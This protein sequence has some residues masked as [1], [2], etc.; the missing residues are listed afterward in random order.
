MDRKFNQRV[1]QQ[2]RKAEA[3]GQFKNLD[4]AG[5]P[6]PHRPG[7]ALIDPMDSVGHRIMAEAGA[8]PEEV[9]LKKELDAL[10]K[11]FGDTTDPDKRKELMPKLADLEM[12]YNIAREA[13][14]K[15]LGTAAP[16]GEDILKGG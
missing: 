14:R 7:D 3:E 5:K 4:G 10:R 8:V 16:S 6:L 15:F 11:E 13:R 12:R 1:E 9:R 2:I